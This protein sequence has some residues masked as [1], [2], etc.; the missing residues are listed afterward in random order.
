VLKQHLDLVDRQL[1]ALRRLRA[2]LSTM[3]E[4]PAIDA[5][6]TSGSYTGPDPGLTWA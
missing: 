5:T 3:V 1:L 6:P 4:V 2:R